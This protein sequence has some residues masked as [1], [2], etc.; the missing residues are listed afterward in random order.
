MDV[1]GWCALFRGL[2]WWDEWKGE[3]RLAEQ[4][5]EE[6]RSHVDPERYQQPSS[7]FD[8]CDWR[9]GCVRLLRA[10]FLVALGR[11]GGVLARNQELPD[12]AFLPALTVRDIHASV[13]ARHATSY[14]SVVPIIAV[15]AP[16]ASEDHA[17]PQGGAT[18]AG[19]SAQAAEPMEYLIHV[20]IHPNLLSAAPSFTR[21]IARHKDSACRADLDL[22]DIIWERTRLV[23]HAPLAVTG[24]SHP[25]F[26]LPP[27]P[28]FRFRC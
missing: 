19:S 24:V 14:D 1:G 17:D 18:P 20:S 7:I 23:E 11:R 13:V 16:W 27:L 12:H 10:S 25:R 3:P 8:V 21:S 6:L 9:T 4:R 5:A 22:E 15:T 26:R 28:R 2:S